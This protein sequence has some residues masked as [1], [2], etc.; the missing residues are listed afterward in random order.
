VI[1]PAQ[2]TATAI[3]HDSPF[4]GVPGVWSPD[5]KRVALAPALL[6]RRPK[7]FIQ[8]SDGSRTP[9][10][11]LDLRNDYVPMDWSSD[12]AAL[13]YWESDNQNQI[14]HY[15]IYAL[16]ANAKPYP[17]FEKLTSNVP[18]ARFS[19]DGKWIAFSSDQSGRSEVYVA[20][21]GPS[22][23][24]VQI[25]TKGGQNVRWMPDGKH[26]L[27]LAADYRVVSTALKLGE[28]A[29][30]VEQHSMFQLPPT[31]NE[32]GALCFEIAPDRKRLLLA[33]PVGRASVPITVLVN[34]QSELGKEVR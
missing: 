23:T 30:A 12:G 14:G 11:S 24:A 17:V 18:D 25:S 27:Y 1:D 21:F 20:P 34:W 32:N 2:K 26:L 4:G 29:Q 13:L 28:N 3:T 7:I 33:A 10:G 31:R 19:P 9:F 8:A 22:G 16:A 5:G 15:S 6:G